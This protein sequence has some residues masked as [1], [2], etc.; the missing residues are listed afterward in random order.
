MNAQQLHAMLGRLSGHLITG[1]P[2]QENEI[3]LLHQSL[4][5]SLLPEDIQQLKGSSF[6]FENSDLFAAESIPSERST[7][8]QAIADQKA[9]QVS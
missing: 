4:S 7:A 5:R 6:V 9:A 1:T 8:L 3:Q 2:Q